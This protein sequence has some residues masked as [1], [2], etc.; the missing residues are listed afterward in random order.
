EGEWPSDSG[1]GVLVG[2]A[3]ARRLHLRRGDSFAALPRYRAGEAITMQVRGLLSSGGAEDEAIVAPL[4]LAQALGGEAGKMRQVLV[5]AITKPEDAFARQDP[6][7]MNAADAER[8]MCSPYALTI[9]TQLRQAIP[10]SSA[11]VIR[12][13]AESEG[14][15]LSQLQLL[16]WLIT[17][18]ALGASALAISAAMTAAVLERRGEIALLKAIGAQDGAI[19]LLFFGEATLLALAGGG[20]GYL[21]GHW[22]GAGIAVR[23]LGH[24]LAWKPALIPLILLLALAVAL[25]GSFSPLRRAMRLEP[26]TAMRGEA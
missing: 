3:L 9:A 11:V 26:A 6:A 25:A 17:L 10:G 2:T 21:L 24:G 19:G 13:V 15:I 7:A 12:P 20:A 16:L 14:A 23:L 4:A 5:S 8:W 22:L 18:L 1:R